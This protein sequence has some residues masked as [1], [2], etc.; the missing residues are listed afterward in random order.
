MTSSPRRRDN[1]A[2][3]P[4]PTTCPPHPALG[5]R[6]PDRVG[7]PGAGVPLSSPVASS[8]RHHHHRTRT[9]AHR[10]RQRRAGTEPRIAGAPTQPAPTGGGALCRT[11]RRTRG[12]VVVSTVP[13]PTP[14]DE[15]LARRGPVMT[16]TVSKLKRVGASTDSF[17]PPAANASCKSGP[18][19][20]TRTGVDPPPDDLRNTPHQDSR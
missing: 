9:P 16:G 10:H 15:Q 8:R 1:A 5:R 2:P 19:T 6:R 11:Y 4:A 3:T 20:K 7:Q 17:V 14:T 12:L 13:A 18:T